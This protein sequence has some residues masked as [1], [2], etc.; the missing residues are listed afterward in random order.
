MKKGRKKV[1]K[2]KDSV[3]IPK[4]LLLGVVAILIIGAVGFWLFGFSVGAWSS[5]FI[6]IVSL[7]SL[8]KSSDKKWVNRKV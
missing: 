8:L 7:V 3:R 1:Q 6:V 2:R 4:N 5:G